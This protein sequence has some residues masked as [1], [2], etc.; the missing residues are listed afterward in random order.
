MEHKNDM[1]AG[2]DDWEEFEEVA[3][4]D[5]VNILSPQS[6]YNTEGSQWMRT[7]FC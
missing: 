6:L 5:N 1:K 3:K 2:K 4:Y 7:L